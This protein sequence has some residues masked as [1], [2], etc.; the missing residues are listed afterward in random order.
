MKTMTKVAMEQKAY[1][2]M[3]EA[4]KDVVLAARNKNEFESHE[5]ALAKFN[6]MVE[7][8]KA[9]EISCDSLVDVIK[10]EAKTELG[11]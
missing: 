2:I 4:A 11:Y 1:K 8:A 5:E 3:K 9:L 6:G 10:D 7:L